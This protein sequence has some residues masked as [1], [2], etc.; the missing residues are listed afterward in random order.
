[1]GDRVTGAVALGR[2]PKDV[3]EFFFDYLEPIRHL[4]GTIVVRFLMSDVASATSVLKTVR[5]HNKEQ[6][7]TASVAELAAAEA[8]QTADAADDRMAAHMDIYALVH[9][10]KDKVD[11]AVGQLH[12]QKLARNVGE[13]ARARIVQVLGH[14]KDT[15]SACLAGSYHYL[16]ERLQKVIRYSEAAFYCPVPNTPNNRQVEHTLAL[17]NEDQSVE[18]IDISHSDKS[19][20]NTVVGPPG[21]GKS[22]MIS[23]IVR[24]HELREQIK[25]I[26]T[27]TLLIDVGSSQRWRTERLGPNDIIFDLAKD[28]NN[29]WVPLP[30]HPLEALMFEG[31]Q[32]D[33]DIN[34]ARDFICQMLDLDPEDVSVASSVGVVR[35]AV[36]ATVALGYPYSMS[37][38]HENLEKAA[39]TAVEKF[40]GSEKEKFSSNWVN[41]TAFIKRFTRG[42][43]FGRVFDPA[44]TTRQNLKGITFFYANVESQQKDPKDLNSAFLRLCHS[45]AYAIADRYGP[46]SQVE[47]DDNKRSIL[48]I[49]D[50]YNWQK[51]FIN[52]RKTTDM[53]DQCRKFGIIAWVLVQ[54]FKYLIMK[55]ASGNDDYSL[56]QVLSKI[57]FYDDGGEGNREILTILGNSEAG[58]KA[59]SRVADRIRERYASFGEHSVGYLDEHRRL[60]RYLVDW[61]SNFLWAITTHSGGMKLRNLVASELGISRQDAADLLAIYGPKKIP[62]TDMPLDKMRAV[63]AAIKNEERFHG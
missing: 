46:F 35:D 33:S 17:R 28:D 56:F 62:K 51:A 31:G 52:E 34:H 55:D 12:S 6:D 32:S 38:L 19:L 37:R 13:E 30:M 60:K 15:H 26:K 58:G 5:D 50:E 16:R 4:N 22:A 53:A 18:Y 63:I 20:F 2:L 59:I 49:V 42:N 3:D 44:T 39:L 47:R 8:V 41:Y 40:S 9:G 43:E 36:K 61:E 7:G 29:N 27:A 1:V 54:N 11:H 23:G 48:W 45:V 14:I 25:H 21:T 57:F 24:A 10:E